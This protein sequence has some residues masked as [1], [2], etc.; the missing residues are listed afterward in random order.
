MCHLSQREEGH[1]SDVL[2][3]S[4]MFRWEFP[5]N[6]PGS[7]PPFRIFSGNFH[8][9]SWITR[10]LFLDT[11]LSISTPPIHLSDVAHAHPHTSLVLPTT[12]FSSFTTLPLSFVDLMLKSAPRKHH[13]DAKKSCKRL[14]YCGPKVKLLLT[15]PFP[16]A[17]Q[18][19][20]DSPDYKP[21]PPHYYVEDL[22]FD[23]DEM[24]QQEQIQIMASA[25]HLFSFCLSLL[26]FLS[27][28]SHHILSPSFHS[29][30]TYHS[31]MFPYLLPLNGP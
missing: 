10:I 31:K 13:T 27:S 28:P 7:L 9:F 22:D 5:R 18:R 16:A 2:S 3:A 12:L 8:L 20:T 24:D 17:T 11:T 14:S 29:S 21:E 1:Q 26:N 25:V 23:L 4:R 6:F 19:F 15:R 30:P